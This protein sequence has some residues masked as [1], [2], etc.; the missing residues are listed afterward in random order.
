[1]YRKLDKTSIYKIINRVVKTI[2]NNNDELKDKGSQ[3]ISKVLQYQGIKI[4]N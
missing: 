4:N 2:K 1:M 3:T